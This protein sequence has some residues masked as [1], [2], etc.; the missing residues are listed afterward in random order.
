MNETIQATHVQVPVDAIEPNNF[1]PNTMN[2][3]ENTSLLEDM[4]PSPETRE[5]LHK[6]FRATV[7]TDKDPWD[8]NPQNS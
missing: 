5:L 7:K 1:N 2:P 8:E 3:E 4:K 6:F